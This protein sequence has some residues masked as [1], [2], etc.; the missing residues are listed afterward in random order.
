MLNLGSGSCKVPANLKVL[1]ALKLKMQVMLINA[2]QQNNGN[3]T[4]PETIPDY[5]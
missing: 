2:R 5:G 4:R 1:I 3:L